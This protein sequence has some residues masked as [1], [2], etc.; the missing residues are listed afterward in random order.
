MFQNENEYY[1]QTICWIHK[2]K[3]LKDVI[4][5][6]F[7]NKCLRLD[8]S[9]SS[10]RVYREKLNTILMTQMQDCSNQS[11]NFKNL[12][13]NIEFILL[14]VLCFRGRLQ[15]SIPPNIQE[16]I[17]I[18]GPRTGKQCLLFFFSYYLNKFSLIKY[19]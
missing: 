9:T 18:E 13:T 12:T 10:L 8:P 11:I 4:S 3:N 15:R 7:P 5:T 6:L 17:L 1:D 19:H 2:N 14:S 16:R